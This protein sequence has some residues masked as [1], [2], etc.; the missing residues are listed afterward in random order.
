MASDEGINRDQMVDPGIDQRLRTKPLGDTLDQLEQCRS[1][2][3]WV[4]NADLGY[5]LRRSGLHTLLAPSD[6]AFQA[7]DSGSPEEYLNRHLLPGAQESFDLSRCRQV[8]TA[9]GGMLPVAEAGLRIGGA[10]IVRADVSCTNGVIHII[11]SEL[12][13]PKA[14]GAS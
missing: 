2:A 3:Q 14:A 12:H 13:P 5:L 6:S 11:D 7:P 10:K 4:R 9:A 8:K 1:F